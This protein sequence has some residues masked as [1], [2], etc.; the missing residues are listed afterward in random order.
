M[1]LHEKFL[2]PNMREAIFGYSPDYSNKYDLAIFLRRIVLLSATLARVYYKKKICRD[3]K[4]KMTSRII[5]K[6]VSRPYLS[7]DNAVSILTVIQSAGSELDELGLSALR[8]LS[9]ESSPDYIDL[10]EIK[11]VL[12]DET[13]KFFNAAGCRAM[14]EKVVACVP[15]LPETEIRND[16]ERIELVFRG[17]VFDIG[18]LFRYEFCYLYRTLQDVDPLVTAFLPL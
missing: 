5:E 10:Y 6:I 7:A 11:T 4:E 17:E 1:E 16:G 15:F 18:D 13:G 8:I 14:I 12:L 9:D 3:P 2:Y